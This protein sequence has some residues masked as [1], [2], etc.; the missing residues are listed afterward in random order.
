MSEINTH[1]RKVLILGDHQASPEQLSALFDDV[2]GIQSLFAATADEALQTVEQAV[3]HC[4]LI[5]VDQPDASGFTVASRLR[6]LQPDCALIFYASEFSPDTRNRAFSVGAIDC[7][8]TFGLDATRKRIVR[9]LERLALTDR[10]AQGKRK[11]E[12]MIANFTD[13]VVSVD[14]QNTV[15]MWNRAAETVFG[16]SANEVIGTKFERF[17][18]PE[19]REAH[20]A[21]LKRF[22]A[23]NS[24]GIVGSDT[25]VALDA[26]KA[27]GSRIKVQLLLSSWTQND[28]IFVT[29]MIKDVTEADYLKKL[30]RT[31][32]LTDCLTRN[33][34][35]EDLSKENRDTDYLLCLVD[36]DHF[37]SVNELYGYRVGDDYLIEFSQHLKRNLPDDCQLYRLGSEEFV[38][39]RPGIATEAE[40]RQF[41]KSVHELAS[42]VSIEQTDR[43]VHRS[44]SLGASSLRQGDDLSEALALADDALLMARADG[45]NTYR[46]VD[47]ELLSA[48]A[49]RLSRPS[50]DDIVA[51]INEGHVEYFLQPI[52]DTQYNKV[53]GFEALI[54]WRR[55][56]QLLG[57]EQFL[58][59]F[60][61]ATTK[62]DFGKSRLELFSAMI[63]TVEPEIPGYVALNVNISDLVDDGAA[64]IVKTLAPL[65]AQRQLVIEISE[66]AIGPR[67]NEENVLAALKEMQRHGFLIALD[68]FGKESSNFNRLL[69]WP[70]DILKVD[71]IFIDRITTEPKTR[72]IIESVVKLAAQLQVSVVAEGVETEIQAQVLRDLGLHLHQGFLYARPMTIGAINAPDFPLMMSGISMPAEV[73]AS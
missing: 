68:D 44:V 62:H 53:Q 29:A 43:T 9:Q 26:L 16:I 13:A 20:A 59:E 36:I 8:G 58:N 2:S 5:C 1:P 18:P 22:H 52:V 7:V 32:E 55:G 11:L 46:I 12:S 70:I 4:A 39:V 64:Q 65:N 57:P 73:R 38:I 63:R 69:D 45:R 24:V 17:V 37:K 10:L 25:P 49:A 19:L 14:S 6:E 33:A 51:G 35:T 34:M 21:G 40:L 61:D 48:L 71:K 67:L 41:A 27:D 15:V 50:Q 28:E 23:G 47:E 30:L 60:Y 3:L 66:V 31:D 72:N 42:G 56:D 54:R